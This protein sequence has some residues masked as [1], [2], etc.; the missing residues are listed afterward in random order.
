MNY[1]RTPTPRI[2]SRT[3]IEYIERYNNYT[4][5]K[6]PLRTF[7]IYVLIL[8]EVRNT[9]HVYIWAYIPERISNIS[10]NLGYID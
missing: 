6:Y 1:I 4:A 2:S 5:N 8:G 9:E 3:G 10:P 7:N